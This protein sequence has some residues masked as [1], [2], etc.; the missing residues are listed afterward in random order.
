MTARR[1]FRPPAPFNGAKGAAPLIYGK[2]AKLGKILRRVPTNSSRAHTKIFVVIVG[3]VAHG[4]WSAVGWRSVGPTAIGLKRLGIKSLD[5]LEENR[6]AAPVDCSQEK[7][8]FRA[9]RPRTF[10][11]R[12]P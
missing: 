4:R 11:W 12:P 3:I 1:N 2:L 7:N 8:N 9:A 5:F 6:S 10:G